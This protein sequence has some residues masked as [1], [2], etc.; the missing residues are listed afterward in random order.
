MVPGDVERA[1]QVFERGYNDLRRQGLKNEVCRWRNESGYLFADRL[2]LASV[3]RFW[4]SGKRSRRRMARPRTSRRCRV[5]CLS[6]AV[7]ASWR[8]MKQV[9]Y[10]RFHATRSSDTDVSLKYSTGT[11]CSQTTRRS[12]TRRHSNSSRWL[13]R[14][15]RRRPRKPKKTHPR[16]PLSAPRKSKRLHRAVQI[17][18]RP[19]HATESRMPLAMWRVH[20]AATD[21]RCCTL[22]VTLYYCEENACRCM[23]AATFTR[24]DHEV[25]TRYPGMKSLTASS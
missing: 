22:F 3:L 8:A 25:Y 14:G 4:K 17:A 15:R 9:R 13:M 12:P 20:T 11:W 1:R 19:K 5:R 21:R 7:V 23:H 2:R 16:R 10:A 6:S 18:S 24:E